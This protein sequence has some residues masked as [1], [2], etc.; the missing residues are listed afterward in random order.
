MPPT[1]ESLSSFQ[2]D[3]ARLESIDRKRFRKAVRQF[4]EDLAANRLPRPGLRVKRVQGAPDI[5]ELSW[6]PDGRATFER[7]AEVVMSE[8]HIIW[9]RIGSHDVFDRP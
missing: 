5:W 2:R 8:A 6:A 1:Y 3:Y 4:V 9:R 7:G